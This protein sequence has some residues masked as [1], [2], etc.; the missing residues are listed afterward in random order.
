MSVVS[1]IK[2]GFIYESDFSSLSTEWEL[3]DFN[4]VLL[5]GG[6][7]LKSGDTPFFMYFNKLTT[8][9]QFVLDVKNI[10][11]PTKVG[12]VGG[13]LVYADEDNFIALEEYYDP[14]KGVVN[15]YPWLRLVRDYNVYSGYWSND[16]KQW[17]L[18]G[19]HN[20]GELS[21]KIG[22]FLDGR[23]EDM[24]IEYI[25]IFRS[26]YITV[27][28]PPPRSEL[29]LVGEDGLLKSMICPVHYPKI[30]FPI[31]SY[32]IPF[33]G[34]FKW[35][36]EDGQEV[37]TE[38]FRNLW[39]GDEF[40]FQ[41]SL[42]LYYKQGVEF[43]QVD[44]NEEEFLGHINTFN[45]DDLN[46]RRI[47]MKVKNPHNYSFYNVGV[48][49]SPYK[50]FKDY[51]EYVSLSTDEGGEYS[52]SINLGTIEP[53]SEKYFWVEVKRAKEVDIGIAEVYFSLKV[54]SN[55]DL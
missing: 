51:S 53:L 40:K 17:E 6:L 8:E 42:D 5:N 18:V 21:P 20:F 54:N 16:G 12:E 39:G 25:R 23:E 1:K 47:L 43:K 55:V 27:H 24:L 4:R 37:E 29:Q 22:L 36:S 50:D 13:I 7:H 9:K 34:K 41:V 19:T 10:Y 15:T 3:S 38:F 14:I 49:V 31:S 11:N 32:G 33:D 48:D 52:E 46:K 28:N 26:I 35:K 30:A 44:A 2:S 45:S